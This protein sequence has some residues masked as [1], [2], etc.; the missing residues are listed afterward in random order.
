M[1]A[2]VAPPAARK[3]EAVAARPS[4]GGGLLPP[5]VVLLLLLVV[6]SS[7]AAGACEL[8]LVDDGGGA[9]VATSAGGVTTVGWPN[10]PYPNAVAGAVFEAAGPARVVFDTLFELEE[11]LAQGTNQGCHDFVSV[12][13]VASGSGSGGDGGEE[14]DADE[15]DDGDPEVLCGG[16]APAPIVVGAGERL[17]FTFSTDGSVVGAG[18]SATCVAIDCGGSELAL[19]ADCGGTDAQESAEEQ[20][21]AGAARDTNVCTVGTGIALPQ[22]CMASRA[23]LFPTKTQAV[24]PLATFP[25]GAAE[26]W[27]SFPRTD[28]VSAFGAPYNETY[29][30]TVDYGVSAAS[31]GIPFAVAGAGLAAIVLLWLWLT[32]CTC[33]FAVC[34]WRCQ[35]MQ[36]C[37]RTGCDC[38]CGCCR[39]ASQPGRDDGRCAPSRTGKQRPLV[40]RLTAILGVLCVGGVV[41]GI[42]VAVLAS[43]DSRE[44]NL[45]VVG[46]IEREVESVVDDTAC[47]FAIAEALPGANYTSDTV[48]QALDAVNSTLEDLRTVASDA[49]SDAARVRDA[50]DDVISIV[51]TAEGYRDVGW[52][53]GI[54]VA[55]G[56]ASLLGILAVLFHRRKLHLVVGAIVAL[57]V[58]FVFCIVMLAVGAGVATGDTCYDI[59][60]LQNSLIASHYPEANVS[61]PNASSALAE[62]I[63]CPSETTAED[64]MSQADSLIEQVIAG[65][66][67]LKDTQVCT[68][69]RVADPEVAR[70]CNAAIVEVSDVSDP[71]S[72]KLHAE[73][74]ADL[75]E[76]MPTPADQSACFEALPPSDVSQALSDLTLLSAFRH[77][78]QG[79]LRCEPVLRAAD[80]GKVELCDNSSSSLRTGFYAVLGAGVAMTGLLLVMVILLLLVRPADDA[81][82]ILP[83]N[84]PVEED[85]AGGGTARE[86]PRG[87]FMTQPPVG[88]RVVGLMVPVSSIRSTTRLLPDSNTS[89]RAPSG[90]VGSRSS[91]GSVLEMA[92]GVNLTHSHLREPSDVN[93]EVVARAVS[94]PL[95]APRQAESSSPAGA[96]GRAGNGRAGASQSVLVPEGLQQM[97]AAHSRE[98]RSSQV[99][100]LG[101]GG[102]ATGVHHD[103]M[104]ASG[105]HAGWS[106]HDEDSNA[107]PTAT[108]VAPPP[109]DGACAACSRASTHFRVCVLLA[110]RSVYRS[111]SLGVMSTA[112]ALQWH[113]RSAD[114]NIHAPDAPPSHPCV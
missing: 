11:S 53:I 54:S 24:P 112:R 87:Q 57:A 22:A 38:F 26:F 48:K 105:L 89:S 4:I 5:S 27:T 79:L 41:A 47:L 61:A 14:G 104:I 107:L 74:F 92:S 94:N 93:A 99:T 91:S 55:V 78:G 35:R 70:Y 103:A 81:Y 102:S 77:I 106:G 31:A 16:V 71:V 113:L 34:C 51:K 95:R 72:C 56:V 20:G 64:A 65:I 44:A 59:V 17:V 83:E 2:R 90:A 45:K 21:A 108:M 97:S 19:S 28:M 80:V 23:R 7:A 12:R 66:N 50:S 96:T 29:G 8:S 9:L 33:C 98:A 68:D 110:P 37:V 6:A 46:A 82:E 18:F 42:I 67:L 88:A 40:R 69:E 39:R 111:G 15:G 43:N 3:N 25:P 36:Q 58:A 10:E 63:E 114:A 84:R 62:E 101:Q 73:R 1:G 60:I 75:C 32:Q 109:T 49:V 30:I 86:P 85:G 76:A 52:I 100:G 13:R